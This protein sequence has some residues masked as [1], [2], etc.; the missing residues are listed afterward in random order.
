[1]TFERDDGWVAAERTPARSGMSIA[2]S[3]FFGVAD[4]LAGSWPR[5]LFSSTATIAVH[6]LILLYFLL[7]LAEPAAGPGVAGNASPSLT[8]FDL[9][10]SRQPDEQK[11]EENEESRQTQPA[12]SSAA[13]QAPVSEWS[14]GKITVVREAPIVVAG[15][16]SNGTSAATDKTAS[17]QT[18]AAASNSGGSGYDPYA[19]AAPQKVAENSSNSAGFSA[20][21]QE[22]EAGVI[23]WLRRK[24]K[25]TGLTGRIRLSLDDQG[26]VVAVST[27]DTSR[28]TAVV[29][30]VE[31]ILKG[32]K[33]PFGKNAS[34]GIQPREI[35]LSI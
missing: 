22:A 19:G 29:S 34:A 26:R 5:A 35:V 14:I 25:G 24:L 10:G 33:L 13:A 17:G 18:Q 30:M 21:P 9:S 32:H 16:S 7:K 6:L 1:M 28:P 3:A 8:L 31:A 20:N 2:S 11:P 4:F 27:D 12:A 15:A 23:H